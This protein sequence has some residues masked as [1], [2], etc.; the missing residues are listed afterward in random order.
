MYWDHSSVKAVSICDGGG[1]SRSA[2]GLKSHK[3]ILRIILLQ[4]RRIALCGPD[5]RHGCQRGSSGC[6]MQKFPTGKFHNVPPNM[7]ADMLKNETSAVPRTA[8]RS[9]YMATE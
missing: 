5:A 3:A 7:P 6:Q 9:N 4:P 2:S 8:L 1:L